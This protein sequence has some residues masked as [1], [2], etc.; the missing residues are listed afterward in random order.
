MITLP[1]HVECGLHCCV[2][3]AAVDPTFT[4]NKASCAHCRVLQGIS[5]IHDAQSIHT[6]VKVLTSLYCRKGSNADGLDLVLEKTWN[7]K[8][9]RVLQPCSGFPVK[10][11]FCC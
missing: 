2:R 6:G 10:P 3:K 5:V 4:E 1:V 7:P 8:P 9:E 11:C